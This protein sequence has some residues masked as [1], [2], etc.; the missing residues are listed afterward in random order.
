MEVSLV[1]SKDIA[2]SIR[3]EASSLTP[4]D[5]E[6]YKGYIAEVD[7]TINKMFGGFITNEG[8]QRVEIVKQNIIVTEDQNELDYELGGKHLGH[9]S[10]TEGF[11]IHVADLDL[12]SIS[13]IKKYLNNMHQGS[14]DL[15]ASA[16]EEDREKAIE[17]VKKLNFE[18]SLAHELAHVYVDPNLPGEINE[19]AALY[20]G[21]E[22][23]IVLFG[24]RYVKPESR[25]VLIDGYEN[26][27]A[28]YGQDFNKLMFGGT[29]NGFKR[30]WM[31]RGVRR[32]VNNVPPEIREYLFA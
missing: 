3:L 16:N 5:A 32:F 23:S 8:R 15:L 26:F 6:R 14:K 1:E 9:D 30:R 24:D 10:T 7:S 31:L 25:A 22:I 20:M 21:S 4:K 2:D 19:L 13:G 28:K 11:R 17:S 12:I 29:V 27:L 18:T